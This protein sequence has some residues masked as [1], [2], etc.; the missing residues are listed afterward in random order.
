MVTTAAADAA[1]CRARHCRLH[2]ARAGAWTARRSSRGSVCSWRHSVRAP[3]GPSRVFSRHCG[4]DDGGDP[5]G[6]S[7]GSRRAAAPIPPALV[8]IVNRCLEKS[9]SARFQTASDLAFALESCRIRR[10]RQ[11][12]SPSRARIGATRRV[13]WLGGRGCCCWRRWRPSRTSISASG[14]VAPS[15]M[16]FQIPPTVE[17]AGPGNFGALS[18]RPSPGFRRAW[19]GW[20]RAA[21]DPDHG[22][23][24]GPASS[25]FGDR[26]HRAATFLVSR[27]T[28]R[29]VRCR[30]QAQEDGRVGRP[31]ANVVRSARGVSPWAARGIATATSSSGTSPAVCCASARPAVPRL[32]SRRSI[33]R[34]RRNSICFRPFFRTAV[35]S[36]TC[37]CRRARQRPAAPTSAR[38]MRSL[39]RKARSG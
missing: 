12:L 14:R 33:R 39:K 35:I 3:V 15:P 28:V 21:L 31:A 24:G 32:P 26:R 27:R 18:G 8:R 36:S 10:A 29:R 7:A 17:F 4:R 16:R 34:G 25:G 38:S 2:G 22:F 11:R 5:Q 30:R 6:G 37:A 13:A 23:A 20:D 9:P 19:P 1:G